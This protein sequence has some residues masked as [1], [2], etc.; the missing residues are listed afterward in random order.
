VVPPAV[1]SPRGKTEQLRTD[2]CPAVGIRCQAR[3]Y[4]RDTSSG[5]G[6]VRSLALTPPQ[7]RE[8]AIAQPQKRQHAQP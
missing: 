6:L 5:N 2:H 1:S 3:E 4:Q 8:S 7:S